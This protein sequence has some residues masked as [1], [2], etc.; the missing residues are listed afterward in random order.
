[1]KKYATFIKNKLTFLGAVVLA[2]IVGGAATAV[3]MAA[4][5]DSNGQINACYKNSTQALRVT[6]PAGSCATNETALS[7]SQNG[8]GATVIHD[9][10]GQVLGDI[11]DMGAI[12]SIS[13]SVNVYSHSL[14]RI[15]SLAFNTGVGQYDVGIANAP[16]FQS[17]DC[18]GQPYD[19]NSPSSGAKLYL[20]RWNNGTSNVYAVDSNTSTASTINVNSALNTSDGETFSCQAITDTET[21]YP[22]T[23]VSLPFTTPIA[24]PLKF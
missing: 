7:W 19:S 15:I 2:A 4:I 11:L 1:M 23:I 16:V 9:A 20:S 8:S 10:N 14:N 13:S 24:S 21:D 12:G 5:P 6:D 3:V 22:F 17:S 18:S